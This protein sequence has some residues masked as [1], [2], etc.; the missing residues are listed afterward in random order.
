MPDNPFDPGECSRFERADPITR[1]ELGGVL[2]RA[3]AHERGKDPNSEES[4]RLHELADEALRE[5]ETKLSLARE[6]EA[7]LDR[8]A[9]RYGRSGDRADIEDAER[10]K[11]S[12]EIYRRLAGEWRATAEMVRQRLV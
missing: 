5:A 1:E 3:F 9:E 10:W 11:E 4:R 6:A 2:E 7:A 12:A 8:A